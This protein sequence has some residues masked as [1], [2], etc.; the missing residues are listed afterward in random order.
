MSASKNFVKNIDRAV[1][2]V[3]VTGVYLILGFCVY[4]LLMPDSPPDFLLFLI[5]T[6]LVLYVA[7]GLT[8]IL[9]R[10]IK[11]ERERRNLAKKLRNMKENI[12]R[13]SLV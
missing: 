12:S 5:C 11:I 10:E 3:Q 13:Q 4:N 6:S 8:K 9:I 7:V 2:I 1:R